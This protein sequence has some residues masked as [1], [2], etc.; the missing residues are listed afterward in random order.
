[1]EQIY[2]V[3]PWSKSM[4]QIYG[5][6]LEASEW[7]SLLNNNG[8]TALYLIESWGSSYITNHNLGWIS[9]TSP[10]TA[11]TGQTAQL[12]KSSGGPHQLRRTRAHRRQ[13][14]QG[15]GA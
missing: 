15:S 9:W 12:L 6:Q 1:M 8:Y 2:G 10:R 11:A 13:Q 7:V 4:E 3:S 5:H 14:Q